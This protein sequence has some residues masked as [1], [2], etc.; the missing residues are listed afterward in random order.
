MSESALDMLRREAREKEFEKKVEASR[1]EQI[2]KERA[3]WVHLTRTICI[4]PLA[5]CEPI[6]E[7]IRIFEQEH[8]SRELEKELKV[9]LNFH[10]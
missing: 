4:E 10:K 3:K 9:A 6:I 2:E 1:K 7:D 8:K 5:S